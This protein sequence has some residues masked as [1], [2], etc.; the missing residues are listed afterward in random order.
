MPTILPLAAAAA[1]PA[2]S[3]GWVSP[4][5]RFRPPTAEE[6]AEQAAAKAREM[7]E[8][9]ERQLKIVANAKK[10]E[11]VGARSSSRRL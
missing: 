4:L 9:A 6:S 3:V 2:S 8:R 11:R 5:S 1:E 10:G 7:A